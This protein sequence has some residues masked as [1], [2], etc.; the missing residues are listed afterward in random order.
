MDSADT[1][2]YI[3]IAVNAALAIGIGI[4]AWMLFDNK[5]KTSKSGGK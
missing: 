4:M 5:E 1:D 3:A 2:K